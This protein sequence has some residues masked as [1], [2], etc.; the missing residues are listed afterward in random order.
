M[1]SGLVS[2][3]SLSTI[4]QESIRNKL[5]ISQTTFPEFEFFRTNEIEFFTFCESVSLVLSM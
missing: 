2:G 5:I 3:S 4:Y 1:V